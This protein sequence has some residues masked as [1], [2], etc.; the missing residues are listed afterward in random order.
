MKF[1]YTCYSIC[2]ASCLGMRL[3]PRS[4]CSK[5]P[6][7]LITLLGHSNNAQRAPKEALYKYWE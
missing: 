3:G 5:I 2:F 1:C 7:A 6:P 4:F